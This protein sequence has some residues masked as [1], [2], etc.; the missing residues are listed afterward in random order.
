MSKN[1]TKEMSFFE[2]LEELR[3]HILRSLLVVAL[4]GIVLFIFQDWFFKQVIFGPT[5]KDFF[6]YQFI[7]KLS[8]A[9][10]L[11]DNMCFSPPEF[12][13]QAIG[14]G[15]AFITSVSISFTAGLI[16]AFPYVFWELWR[17]VSPG[18]YAA[19]RNAAR[20]VVFICSF[21][22]MMGVGFGYYII[23]PFAINFLV[24]YTIP[25]VENTPTLDSYIG[26][27][28]M[29]TLPMGLV[30][31][32]PIVVYFLAK[33]GLIGPGTM[34]DFRRH[35]VVVILIVAAFLSP[36]DA[37]SQVLI[38]L[39]LFGLY[40]VSILVAAREANK[41]AKREAEE[42]KELEERERSTQA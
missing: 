24:G 36:P 29:F 23:A 31:E 15:E 7:C 30:F 41:R 39:P 1:Q 22:F 12:K 3:W 4:A 40:E 5:Q 26:Y 6:S 34:R 42:E 13:K 18:L 9:V 14:F 28:V 27:M 33:V 35:A 17:F 11:G 8:H 25:G 2:H 10:G 20:G 37:V 21:L 38:A 16:F 19:E 32:L